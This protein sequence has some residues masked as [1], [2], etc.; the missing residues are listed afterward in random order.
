MAN[1]ALGEA[2]VLKELIKQEYTVF[3]QFDGQSP[4]DM[5]AYKNNVL[6]R[7]SVKSTKSLNN[8][9]WQIELRQRGLN[10]S[11]YFD[12][13]ASDILAIY[14][15]PED[16]VILLESKSITSKRSINIKQY[17]IVV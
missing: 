17:G 5:V 6:Y 15:E 10:R 13:D 7:V 12:P 2:A 8:N 4:F 9:S 14:I 1:G 3:T 11:S 16:R